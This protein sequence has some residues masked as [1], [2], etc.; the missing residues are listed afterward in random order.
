MNRRRFLAISAASLPVLVRAAEPARRYRVAVIGAT[1]RGDYGHGIDTMWQHIPETEFVAVADADADGLSKA[2]TRLKTDQGFADYREMLAAVKPDIVAVAPRRPDQ[3]RDMILA[4]VEHGARGIY[5]E[6][7]LCRTP[8]EAD[9]IVAACDKRGVKC[10]VAHRVRWH[11]ALPVVKKYVDGDGIGKLLEIRCRGKEDDRGGA[12]DLWVL[13]PHTFNIAAMFAG[14]AVA[15]SGTLLTEGRPSVPEDVREGN[16]SIGPVAGNEAHARFE[17]QSGLPVFFDSVQNAG[18]PLA[19]FG[20]QLIGTEGI[21][22]IRIDQ[23]EL[24]HVLNGNPFKPDEE[25]RA[26]VPISG[27]GFGHRDLPVV[28]ERNA[29][30]ETPGRDLIAAIEEDRQPLCSAADGR[31]TIEMICGVLA[32]HRQGSARVELPLMSRE[33]PLAGW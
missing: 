32:S 20:L 3:H 28:H 19:G 1:G 12:V 26:W 31:E 11:P 29:S 4:A 22:D 9:E 23:P 14:P 16:D 17:T 10:A 33:H 30:H 25:L 8:A 18:V 5:V 6:K 27:I 13:G 24:A 7:P 15:C 21:V 2:K